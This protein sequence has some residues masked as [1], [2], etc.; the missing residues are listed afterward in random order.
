MSG[1]S[2]V[3]PR[4]YPEAVPMTTMRA[5][6]LTSRGV[7]VVR[8]AVPRLMRPDDVRVR[9]SIVGLCRTDLLIADGKL[10]AHRPLVLGHEFAGLVDAVGPEAEGVRVGDRV[11]VNP[12]FGCGKCPVC[13]GGDEINC[14]DRTMLGHD[15]DGALAE[16]VVVPAANLY[17]VPDSVPDPVAAY[18]EPVA[19]AL[20]ALNAGIAPHQSVCVVGGN[21]FAVLLER[22][23]KATGI[24]NVTGY[25]PGHHLPIPANE[26]DFVIETGQVEQMMASMF[27]AAKPG[28]TVVLK[29]RVPGSLNV[30]FQVAVRKQ[31]TIKN[32][33]YGSFRRAMALLAEGRLELETLLGPVFAVADWPAAFDAARTER[34][35][36]F[37]QPW[38]HT[39]AVR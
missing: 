17:R 12:V 28:G 31:L 7:E 24:P 3:M 23:L 18:A 5:L 26:F 19:A 34:A 35:K 38:H 10:P 11:A 15:R 22:V 8:V 27:R 6:S 16:F 37:I 39:A 4:I 2:C 33:N 29:S 20:A 9:A 32:V 36:V 25:T 13:F 21:R 1:V 14:P 30:D